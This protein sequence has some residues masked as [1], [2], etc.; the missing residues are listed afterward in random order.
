LKALIDHSSLSKRI[1][2]DTINRWIFN[3]VKGK[4]FLVGGYL[5]DALL[6]RHSMD[7]DYVVDG[8]PVEIAREVSRKFIG[9]LIVFRG[10]VCRVVLPDKRVIDFTPLKG[11]VYD[12]LMHRD[13]TINAVAWSPEEGLIDPSGGMRDLEKGVIRVTSPAN[14]EDDP[15]RVLRAYRHAAE[16]SFKI[17]R[18]TS[19]HLK[20]NAPGLEGIPPE[21]IT[22][23]FF[24]ILNQRGC[25]RYLAK[26]F[27]DGVLGV[28]V[29][30]DMDSLKEN[31]SNLRAFESFMNKN[32]ERIAYFL[33]KRGLAGFLGEE[34]SQ[35][36][37]REG[38][39][40]LCLI[41]CGYGINK[42][43][44]LLRVATRIK[45][46]V[47]GLSKGL[48]LCS[49]RITDEALYEIFSRSSGY[50]YEAS[51]L[52]SI[53]RKER[54]EEFL[55]KADNFI[56]FKKKPLLN[57]EEI[58]EVLGCVKGSIIGEAQ[59]FLHKAQFMGQ[60]MTKKTAKR[61]IASNF[62]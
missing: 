25:H 51:I 38:L 31:L 13:F 42:K 55:K 62:T 21:R 58:K 52:L 57:G 7:I 30:I 28:I 56:R 4:V 3:N 50:V 5:R 12:D 53:R 59:S 16:L 18:E 2:S 33:N 37:E 61:L 11:D 44:T 20:R 8:D 26:A 27:R 36:L 48:E 49:G 35:G 15:L 6:G 22:Y 54:L 29:K 47:R 43:T 34:V 1:Q 14:L 17:E 41:M 19:R 24:R 45:K 40:R 32:R 46:A 23:E 60:A 9:T 39:L 10:H